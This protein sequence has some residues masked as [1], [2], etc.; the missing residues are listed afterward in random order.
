M[1]SQ[2]EDDI[3]IV[4]SHIPYGTKTSPSS[5]DVLLERLNDG[6][7]LWVELHVHC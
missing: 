7:G 5:P 2:M 4:C 1:G 3:I 6:S